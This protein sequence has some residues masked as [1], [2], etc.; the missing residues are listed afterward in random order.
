MQTEFQFI[1]DK[2]REL[3][4]LESLE[5]QNKNLLSGDDATRSVYKQ[6]ELKGLINRVNSLA[7][8][9]ANGRPMDDHT[10]TTI[11]HNHRGMPSLK[12]RQG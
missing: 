1:I 8:D 9:V 7:I 10:H 6:D 4:A 5:W 11:E 2:L 3:L 12:Y